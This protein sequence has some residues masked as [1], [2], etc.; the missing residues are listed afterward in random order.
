M[1][2]TL[3]AK[4]SL[5]AAHAVGAATVDAGGFFEGLLIFGIL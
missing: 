3:S 5:R 2:G 4:P 1:V